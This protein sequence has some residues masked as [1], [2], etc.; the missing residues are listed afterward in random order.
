[1][2]RSRVC[3]LASLLLCS[4]GP[5][6]AQSLT[7]GQ[8]AAIVVT[9]NQVDVDAG[10]LAETR[11][12]TEAVKSFAKLMVTDHTAVNDSALALA[13][14]V[15]LAP[16]DNA[17]SQALKQGGAKNVAALKDLSGKAFDRAY[18]AHEVT[19]HQTVIDALDKQLV[20]N[21]SNAELKA[22]LVKVRPAFVTHL[23]HAKHLAAEI[24]GGK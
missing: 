6:F 12:S 3:A 23:E 14:K 4:A 7:D 17:T 19:Y 20:P 22:L 16:E 1:M 24:G 10:R 15:H 8:I 13:K 9:A 5:T 2:T 18:V 11:G 21:A